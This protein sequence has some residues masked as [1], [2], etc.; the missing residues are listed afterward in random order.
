MGRL[1][2]VGSLQ[3]DDRQLGQLLDHRLDLGVGAGGVDDLAQPAHLPG[4]E[5]GAQRPVEQGSLLRSGARRGP[6]PPAPCACP[7]SRSSPAG[8]PV[9][10]GVAEDAQQVVPQLERLAQRQP[11]CAERRQSAPL[12]RRRGRRRRAAVARW[13]TS[14]TCSAARSSRCPRRPGRA[15]APRRRGTGPV[16][17]SERHRSKTSMAAATRASGSPHRRS[18]SSAQLSSR[19]PSRIAPEAPYCSGSPRQPSRRCSAAKRAVRRRAAAP[20]VGRVHVVVVDQGA[21]VQELEGSARAHQC[22]LVLDVGADGPISPVAEGGPEPLAARDRR[23]ASASRRPA[24]G[25]SGAEP[26]GHLGEE[27]VERLLDAAA[28]CRRR[29]SRSRRRG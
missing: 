4:V 15:P 21:G 26:V 25:P 11:E 29:P 16:I 6:A 17:T 10:A 5:R 8:L 9:V 27:L 12:W 13:S 14:R 19:S 20:G 7:R 1:V 22:A 24:S 18:S 3:A 28:E 23:R 2:D